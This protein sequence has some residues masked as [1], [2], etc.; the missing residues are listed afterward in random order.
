MFVFQCVESLLPPFTMRKES[1]E[2]ESLAGKCRLH[3]GRYESRR[4][5]QTLHLYTSTDTLA[6]KQKARVRYSGRA[7]ICNEGYVA[8]RTDIFGYT[9]Y[10]AMFVELMVSHTSSFYIEMMK[11][12]GC[13]AC[14]FG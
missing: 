11:Q 2:T 8:S 9:L 1:F 3:K 5:G 12:Y 4:S 6:Y 10:G 7:G 13:I 14:I